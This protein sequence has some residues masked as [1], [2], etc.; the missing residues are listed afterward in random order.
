[1]GMLID[2]V[3][4]DDTDRFMVDGAF[5]REVSTLTGRLDASA[6]TRMGGTDTGLI[7]VVSQSCPWSHA[8]TLAHTFKG[9]HNLPIQV[10]GGPRIE[11][12]G[13]LPDGPLAQATGARHLH[14]L[15]T[16]SDPNFT[17]RA[18]IP[19]LYDV[20][21]DRILSD[22]SS[23]LLKAIDAAGHGPALYPPGLREQI[24]AM[25]ALNYATLTNAVYRAG[26]ARTQ[27]TYQQAV[28]QV[29][30]RLAMLEQHLADRDVLVGDDLTL[31]DL[32]LFACLVRFDTAYA[33][34]FRCTRHRLT[35]FPALWRYTRRIYNRP[36][37]AET[38]NFKVIREGYF[39]NDGDSNPY[40]ILPDQPALDWS[41]P[42]GNT[43]G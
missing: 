21:S 37:V 1:M 19:V 9:L 14:Q 25:V 2:G 11:G 39:L 41:L 6:V 10:A 28:D 20:E 40:G 22:D 36:G 17:G 24:D 30:D 23:A 3:W 32:R 16:R 5:R 8:V 15:Y 42:Q 26:L 31:C 12:Y 4:Q 29:F 7:L 27:P 35:D 13:L 33:T 43:L 34:H 18:T 38:V